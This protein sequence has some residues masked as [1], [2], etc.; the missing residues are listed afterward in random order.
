MVK[1][2][3]LRRQDEAVG[4]QPANDR[5]GQLRI[6]VAHVDATGTG[7]GERRVSTF[8]HGLTDSKP[9]F[10]Q[11]SRDVDRLTNDR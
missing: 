10:S 11:T 7:Q 5:T 3:A 8:G 2:V 6:G 1:R 4:L 9:R